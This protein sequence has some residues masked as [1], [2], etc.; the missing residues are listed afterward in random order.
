MA[1]VLTRDI[2]KTFNDVAAVNGSTL[3]VP[4]ASS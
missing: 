1:A 2:T 3:T 4:T